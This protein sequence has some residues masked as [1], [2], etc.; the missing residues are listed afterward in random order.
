MNTDAP[1][2][3]APRGPQHG[4]DSGTG[5]GADPIVAIARRAIA[6][7]A[8]CAAYRLRATGRPKARRARPARQLQAA[9]AALTGPALA[10]G[11]AA[12]RSGVRWQPPTSAAART[13]LVAYLA[14]GAVVEELIWRGPLLLPGGTARRAAIAVLGGCG[15][16]GAH[17]RRDGLDGARVHA[18]T[19][20]AW[21]CATLLGGRLRWPILGHTLYN[22]TVV[23]LAPARRPP[24]DAR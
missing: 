5:S 2:A 13:I 22:I 4:R 3:P 11:V 14:S 8:L 19:T 9:V 16:V 21:T 10:I 23:C 1:G 6:A 7:A 12:V 18:L 24:A 17:L 20:S 15:F